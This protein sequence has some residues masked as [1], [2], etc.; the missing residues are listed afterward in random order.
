MKA[1]AIQLQT[2]SSM[3]QLNLSTQ[4]RTPSSSEKTKQKH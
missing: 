2:R 1:R 4:N 3:Y